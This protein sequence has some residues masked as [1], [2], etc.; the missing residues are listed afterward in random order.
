M[1]AELQKVPI[2]KLFPSSTNPRKSFDD[3]S[4]K[5]LIASVKDKGIIV[6]PIVCSPDGSGKFMIVAGER[7]YRAAV[8]LKLTE[9]SCIVRDLSDEQVLEI[10][11][12]ENLQRKDIHPLEEA[13][14]FLQLLTKGKCDMRTVAEKVGKSVAFITQRL[15]LTEL[16]PPAKKLFL[17]DKMTFGH[18]FAL[19]RLQPAQQKEAVAWVRRGDNL[20]YFIENID[21]NFHLS[22]KNAAFRIDDDSLAPKAG[23]C[24]TCPKRTGANPHL[25]QDIK[26]T[27]VCTD[28]QCYQEKERAF[29]KIQVGTHPDAVM[30]TAGHTEH[31]KKCHGLHPDMWTIAGKEKCGNLAEG[32]VVET[33]YYRHQSDQLR[34]GQVLM[35]CTKY[36]ACKVHNKFGGGARV[37]GTKLTP[38]EKKRRIA[39]RRNAAID[40][41]LFNRSVTVIRKDASIVKTDD[42]RRIVLELVN[43]QQF[44]YRGAA[45]AIAFNLKAEGKTPSAKGSNGRE[46]LARFMKTADDGDLMAFLAMYSIAPSYA[47]N[48]AHPELRA[49]AKHFGVKIEAVEKEIDAAKKGT[50]EKTKPQKKSKSATA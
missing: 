32:V 19:S 36:Q 24:V 50:H 26:Q 9:I 30:L 25:F 17:A 41:M 43:D 5:D 44:R 40:E 20:R 4:M 15:K 39:T 1:N 34:A 47:G 14:G 10:Q 49:A 35:V 27:D 6:P 46:N 11:I 48:G 38:E 16:I 13:E 33:N 12:V 8:A 37:A 28:P 22:L 29:V 45:T 2:G 18:A 7:R 21:Q 42:L 31:G 23:A 3:D